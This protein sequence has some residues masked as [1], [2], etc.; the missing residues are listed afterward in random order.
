MNGQYTYFNSPYYNEDSIAGSALDNIIVLEDGLLVHGY[1][2]NSDGSNEYFTKMDYQCNVVWSS[3]EL[4]SDGTFRYLTPFDIF[5]ECSSGFIISIAEYTEIYTKANSVVIKLDENLDEEWR[6]TQYEY[7]N[8]SV[9]KME[10][11]CVIECANGDFV[12]FGD[13]TYHVGD[14]LQSSFLLTRISGSGS[15]IWSK[16]YPNSLGQLINSNNFFIKSTDI[17]ELDNGD[18]LGWYGRTSNYELIPSA[19]L[20]DEDGNFIDAISWG[21]YETMDG[22]PYGVHIGNDNFLYIY[23]HANG[24]FYSSETLAQPRAGIISM[25]SDGNINTQFPMFNHEMAWGR[26]YDLE[27]CFDSNYLVLGSGAIPGLMNHAFLLQMDENGVEQWYQQYTPPILYYSLE[28]FDLEVCPDGGYVFGGYCLGIEP[29]KQMYW[30][31]KTDACGDV[32][33]DGCWPVT[34]VMQEPIAERNF[35]VYPNPAED[36][37]TISLPSMHSESEYL[38]ISVRDIEGNLVH[39]FDRINRQTEINLDISKW[40]SGAYHITSRKFMHASSHFAAVL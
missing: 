28:V 16:E 32:E 14:E 5:K 12:A 3:S 1:V 2:A 36:L 9:A 7:Q 6:F 30:L 18:L 40:S 35:S 25:Y 38:S 11:T 29:N 4:L 39:S 10:Y 31:V 24:S 19:I 33:Y 27:Q 23:Q 26:I 22:V 34:S 15:E 21:D 20:F 37:I 8:D 13:V 17:F